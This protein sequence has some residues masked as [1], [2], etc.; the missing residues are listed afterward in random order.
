MNMKQKII[1]Y[2]CIVMIYFVVDVFIRQ[3]PWYES[4]ITVIAFLIIFIVYEKFFH[5][6][7][8]KHKNDAAN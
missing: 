2:V 6:N 1:F 8:P 5:S 4:I 7:K 3:N